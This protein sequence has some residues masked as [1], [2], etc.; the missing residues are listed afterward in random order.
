M[1]WP[2]IFCSL[3]LVIAAGAV[4]INDL[5]G[6]TVWT[7]KVDGGLEN[8]VYFQSLDTILEVIYLPKQQEWKLGNLQI[9]GAKKD[10]PLAS[11]YWLDKSLKGKNKDQVS[12]LVNGSLCIFEVHDAN[13][14]FN[15]QVR[16]YYI[17]LFDQLVE[18]AFIDGQW[19]TEKQLGFVNEA[20][21]G[22]AVIRTIRNPSL[23]LYVQG[24]SSY[25]N[26]IQEFTYIDR[27]VNTKDLGKGLVGTSIAATN[28]AEGNGEAIRVFYQWD[29]R[30][31]DVVEMAFINKGWALGNFRRAAAQK[32]QL[33][34]AIWLLFSGFPIG[35]PILF[36]TNDQLFNKLTLYRYG[37][38]TGGVCR[39]LWCGPQLLG[40]GVEEFERG[41]AVTVDASRLYYRPPGGALGEMLFDGTQYVISQTDIL[42]GL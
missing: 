41:I 6:L 14:D 18:K 5:S 25:D 3:A 1:L 8:H 42:S 29:I 22:I 33:V 9:T 30:P 12:G 35:F 39:D 40:N 28:W 24:N 21:D 32:V 17:D 4:V 38:N 15:L 16:V 13:Q 20:C 19:Q 26:A 2:S 7:K 23:R 10:T 37:A 27:W 36:A 31:Y 34:A 11:V